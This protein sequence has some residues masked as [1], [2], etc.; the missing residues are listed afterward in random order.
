MN[1]FWKVV[2]RLVGGLGLLAWAFGGM[3][4][5]TDDVTPTD[6]APPP[7]MASAA[8]DLLRKGDMV[9]ITYSNIP[10]PPQPHQERIKDDGTITLPLIGSVVAEGKNP[11]QLQKV[12]QDAYVPKYYR[13][14]VVTVRTEDRYFYVSGEVKLPNKYVYTP[15]VTVLKAVASAG[16]FTDFAA[17]TKVEITRSTGEKIEIDCKK[18]Q[19]KPKL[20]LSIYPDDRVFVPRRLY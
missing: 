12:I 13:N 6:S 14:M 5:L 4:C 16:G 7:D 3:G 15:G 9:M 19:K 11:G 18:A 10:T 1:L 20:D 17:R 8:S 2:S